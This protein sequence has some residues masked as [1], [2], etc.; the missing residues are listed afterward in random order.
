MDRRNFFTTAA[1]TV[2]AASVAGTATGATFNDIE[3]A[4]QF[5][6]WRKE[7]D[8]LWLRA[9]RPSNSDEQTAKWADRNAEV[10]AR[11]LTTRSD[12]RAGN[13][14]KLRTMQSICIQD[15]D[16]AMAAAL[17]QVADYLERQ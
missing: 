8:N 15:L 13:A 6:A 7:A 5:A 3:D 12:T 11:I 17:G 2:I 10:E 9:N 16:P 14:I 4:D 1:V